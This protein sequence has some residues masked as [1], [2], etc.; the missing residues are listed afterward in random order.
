M[1]T[2]FRLDGPFLAALVVVLGMSGCREPGSTRIV[3]PD[4]S[5]MSHV[6]CGSDQGECFRIAGE[7]C[8]GGYDMKPVMRGSDGNFLVRCRAAGAPVVAQAPPPATTLS[9]RAAPDVSPA[10]PTLSASRAP[11]DAWP[12]ATEPWPA[13]YPW[14]P[15]EQSTS[16]RP[17]S[18]APSGEVDLGY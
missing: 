3:G 12:P 13:A 17:V 11:G 1:P 4:G 7:L 18:P 9:L 6:H 2:C 14:G 16:P 15:P 10:R 8:P 5:R